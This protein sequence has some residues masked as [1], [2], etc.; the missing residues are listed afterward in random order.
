MKS[1]ILPLILTITFIVIFFIFYK[2]LKN[3]NIYTPDQ[4]SKKN[5]PSFNAK[6]FNQDLSI[7]SEDL[8]KKNRLYLL[9]IW[10]SWCVPCKK[11][12]PYLIKLK[13]EYNLEI[14]GLNYKDKKKNAQNFLSELGNPYTK[15]ILDRDGT[16]AI[17]WGA[18]GVPE[19]FVV[20]DEKIIKKFIGPLDDKSYKEIQRLLK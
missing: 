11:E 8:F 18:F 20:L 9:N 3:S 4:Y 16:L 15:I 5:I 7:T 10:S 6:L 12:H 19:T 17:E 13:K 1:K 2:G 14:I